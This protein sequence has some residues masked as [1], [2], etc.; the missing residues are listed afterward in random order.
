MLVFAG[1]LAFSAHAADCD[2]DA[3]GKVVGALGAVDASMRVELAALGVA[4][5]CKQPNVKAL[6]QVAQLPPDMRRLIDMKVGAEALELWMATCPKGPGALAA[7]SRE[8]AP[9]DRVALW[10][11][12][13]M[14]A[15]G[16]FTQSE[17]TGATGLVVA[18][19][20]VGAWLEADGV[21]KDQAR[22]IARALAGLP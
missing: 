3:V 9:A 17:W 5:A 15:R 4:E 22:A 12:C 1:F 19:L 18:P 13:S 21:A 14:E 20:L 6:A 11:T 8:A 10:E 7:A 2:R 16:H